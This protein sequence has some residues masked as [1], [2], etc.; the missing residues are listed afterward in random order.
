METEEGLGGIEDLI[1]T[2]DTNYKNIQKTIIM[3]VFINFIYIYNLIN[4]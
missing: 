3:F 1:D 2:E 4:I